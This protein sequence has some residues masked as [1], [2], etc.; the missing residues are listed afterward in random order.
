MS[1]FQEG[2]ELPNTW[3]GD[4]F[5]QRFAKVELDDA[6]DELFLELGQLAQRMHIRQIEE[7]HHQPRLTNW[8]AWGN[9]ID[10]IQLSPVWQTAKKITAD[11]KLIA[12][13]Y[14]QGRTKQMLMNYLVQGSLDIYSCPL[15]MT[16]GAAT[17]LLRSQN[18]ELIERAVPHLLGRPGIESWTSGQWM[19]ERPGGSDVSK[20][21]T[22]AKLENGTWQLWGDKWFTSATTSEMALALAKTSETELTLFYVETR[23]PDGSLNNIRIN[24]LKEKFGTRSVPT[25]ELTL[26]GTKATPVAGVGSGTKLISPMLHV[27]RMWNS[28]MSATLMRKLTLLSKDYSKKRTAFGKVI[29]EIPAHKVLISKL[30]LATRSATLLGLRSGALL[31]TPLARVATGIAKLHTA[32]QAVDTAAWAME[33]F[34]GAG[35]IENTG[36]PR[37]VADIHVLPIWEGTTNVLSADV[38][39]SLG[40]KETVELLS[41]EWRKQLTT[42]PEMTRHLAVHQDILK[43]AMRVFSVN[44]ARGISTEHAYPIAKQCGLIWQACLLSRFAGLTKHPSDVAAFQQFVDHELSVKELLPFQSSEILSE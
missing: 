42:P 20:S 26:D 37:V 7:A 27:T 10:D 1:F 15:A 12:S 14:S 16:D 6:S 5:I 22:V 13:G 2:P 4:A 3:L 8:D 36:I 19:T 44:L 25:A 11:Y 21:E 43:R 41:D 17:C 32:R 31:D 23:R 28:V 24:R 39:R 38:A 40:S 29:G 33:S 35:Y 18:E 9:R 34:G 30:E